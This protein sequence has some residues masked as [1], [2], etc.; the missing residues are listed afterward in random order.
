MHMLEGKFSHIAVIFNPCP[1]EYVN[2]VTLISDYQLI[3]LLDIMYS[4]SSQA[5]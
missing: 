3:Q 4:I 1:A 2:L 5:T